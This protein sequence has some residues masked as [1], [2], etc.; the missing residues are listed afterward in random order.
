MTIALSIPLFERGTNGAPSTTYAGVNL[1]D[2]AT[3]VEISIVDRGGF[4]TLHVSCVMDEDTAL[5]A[6]LSWLG[7]STVVGSPD[8]EV[9][10][11][12]KLTQ[13]DATFGQDPRSISFEGMANHIRVRYTTTLGTPGATAFVSDTESQLLYGVKDLIMPLGKSDSAEAASYAATELAQRK[14]P[15]M[16]PAATVGSGDLGG[17][18]VEFTF[19]GWYFFL[20]WLTTHVT[21]TTKIATTTQ[22]PTLIEDYNDTNN[23]FSETTHRITV[24]GMSVTQETAP[25]TTYRAKIEDLLKRGDGTNPFAWGVYENREFVIEAWAGA[26]PDAITYQRDSGSGALYDAQGN[27]VEPWN[28]RPNAMYQN[29]SLLDPAPVSGAQDAAARFY[30]AR[31]ICR[32]DQNGASV[33]LE[34]GEPS[35]LSAILVRK[36]A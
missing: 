8:A 12:G 22:I 14:N 28:V 9:C 1:V 26:T 24:T 34:P 30:V 4:E 31:T 16:R 6:L 7:R 5:D 21:T 33:D 20:D 17:V 25:D 36:Y 32:I 35:D 19:T 27:L 11:E 3:S 23:F 10:F 18:Q 15:R 2:W 13:I 29:T